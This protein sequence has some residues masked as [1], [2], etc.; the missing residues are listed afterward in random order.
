MCYKDEFEIFIS[1]FLK[2]EILRS[3]PILKNN[4]AHL[5]FKQICK[6]NP[7]QNFQRFY[8]LETS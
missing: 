6:K 5:I 3:F 1:F 2:S 7:P 4:G 8:L